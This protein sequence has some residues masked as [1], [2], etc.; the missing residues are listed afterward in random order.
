MKEA[1]L[2]KREEEYILPWCCGLDLQLLLVGHGMKRGEL[3][4]IRG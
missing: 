4:H 3:G 2:E 1:E